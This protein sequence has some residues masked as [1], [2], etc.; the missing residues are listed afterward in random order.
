LRIR[1]RLGEKDGARA[2][3]AAHVGRSPAALQL[4]DHAGEGR[5][6]GADQVGVVARSEESL[7]AVEQ[8]GV[9]LA[10]FHPIPRAKVAQSAIANMI[11]ILDDEI[12]AR[13]IDRASR[14][15][16]AG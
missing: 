15:R 2:M 14:V 6:P 13:Q 4:R 8:A 1:K 9:M 5:E 11:E 16:E 12:R 7:R 3:A 10:P